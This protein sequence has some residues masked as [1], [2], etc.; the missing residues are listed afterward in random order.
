MAL[1][2]TLIMD[3]QGNIVQKHEGIANYDTGEMV[4]FLKLL[5]ASP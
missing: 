1:R 4:R 2:P 3:A 5:V